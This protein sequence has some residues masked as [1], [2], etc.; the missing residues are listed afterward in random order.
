M[1]S[2]S[3]AQKPRP[4]D[5]IKVRLAL[6]TRGW[7]QASLATRIGKSLTAV[8]LTIN[9]N[10]YPDVADLIRAELNLR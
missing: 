1:S 7:T 10:T 8:N 2:A 9:H 6:V 4:L 3:Q 5:P